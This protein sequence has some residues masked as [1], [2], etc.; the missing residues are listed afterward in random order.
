MTPSQQIARQNKIRRMRL[1]R[2]TY[3]QIGESL[4]ITAQ[5]VK[6]ILETDYSKAEPTEPKRK[7]NLRKNENV[8]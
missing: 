7:K 5:R 2:F 1:Q 8:A 4:G 6:A 3:A